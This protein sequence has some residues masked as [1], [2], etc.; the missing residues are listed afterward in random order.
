MTGVEG[1][2]G[3]RGCVLP[4]WFHAGF[5]NVQVEYSPHFEVRFFQVKIK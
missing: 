5:K 4:A 3:G 2:G 1:G